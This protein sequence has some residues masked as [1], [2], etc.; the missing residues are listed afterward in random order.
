MTEHK[1]TIGINPLLKTNIT[2]EEYNCLVLI[3]SLPFYY[4]K[5]IEEY[6]DEVYERKNER[7]NEGIYNNKPLYV[8]PRPKTPIV[9]K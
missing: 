8:P 5:D 6:I 7:K 3:N 2:I 1:Q 9:H 4:E